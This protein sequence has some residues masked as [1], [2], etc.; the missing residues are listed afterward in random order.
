M[1]LGYTIIY[2]VDVPATLNFYAKAF[3][4][5]IKFLHESN[6]YGEM[7]TGA[8]T[9]SFA[10]EALMKENKLN[11]RLNRGNELAAAFEIGLVTAEVTKA[12]N[13]AVNAGAQAISR[14]VQ[15]PWGQTVAY[16]RD[17]NGVLVEICS[18]MEG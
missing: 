14:P 4:L 2:V 5:E 15:K 12:F 17:L 16:V 3:G 1:K 11:L 9:L 18:P 13:V 10:S 6:Q 7:Q 8:T